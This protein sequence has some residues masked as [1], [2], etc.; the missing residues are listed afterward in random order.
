MTHKNLLN[1][2]FLKRFSWKLLFLNLMLISFSSSES[3]QHSGEKI[4]E[5]L[6][7]NEINKMKKQE[8]CDIKQ[9]YHMWISD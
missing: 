2:Y 7:I 9:N 6:N 4:K 8:N 5:N 3:F 1:S